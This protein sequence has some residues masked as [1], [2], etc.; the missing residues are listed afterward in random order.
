MNLINNL[1]QATIKSRM[2][3]TTKLPEESKTYK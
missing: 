2:Q 1:D 3:V